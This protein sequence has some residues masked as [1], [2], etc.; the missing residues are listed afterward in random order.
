MTSKNK[1]VLPYFNDPMFTLDTIFSDMK[2]QM[3]IKEY[4]IIEDADGTEIIINAAGHNPAD[5]EITLADSKLTIKST[6]D[7]AY[8]GISRDINYTYSKLQGVSEDDIT[9]T[10]VNGLIKIKIGKSKKD[11]TKSK[12]IK[13][14]Y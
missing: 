4:S 1:Y 10:F 11:T 7:A 8:K 2:Q 9:A 5:V 6:V 12:S 13:L 3:T 14:N